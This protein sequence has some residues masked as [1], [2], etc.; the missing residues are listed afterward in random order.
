MIL[1]I[2]ILS[3]L[4]LVFG[5]TTFNLLRKNERLEDDIESSDKYLGD[6]YS[7]MKDAYERMVKVDRLGSFEADDES[8]FI[9][10]KIK[11]ILEDINNEYNLNGETQTETE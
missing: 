4:T 7:S 3:V 10:D 5:F 2:V 11:T 9:F 8:G 1:T 6:A